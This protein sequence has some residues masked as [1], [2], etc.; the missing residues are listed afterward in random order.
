MEVM[1]RNEIYVTQAYYFFPNSGSALL[2]IRGPVLT[3]I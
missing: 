3:D 1:R 2:N